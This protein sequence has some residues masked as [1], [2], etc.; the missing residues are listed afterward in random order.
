[1]NESSSPG[2]AAAVGAASGGAPRQAGG[3]YGA[4]AYV[5]D[6]LMSDMP[7]GEWLGWLEAYWSKI[8]RP[9]TVV[10]LGCGTGT[11]AI[12]LAQAGIHVTGIDLSE[13]MLAVARHKEAAVRSELRVPGA[14]RWLRADM[15]EWSLPEPVDAAVSLCDCI[16]YLPTEDDVLR[17]FRRAY[18]GLRPGGSFLFDA[19][20]R[21]RLDMYAENEPFCL[22]DDEVSYI[23]YCDLD[24]DAD[25]VTHRLTFFLPDGDGRYAR[26]KETHRQ[27]AYSER[28]LRELL[29]EAGFADVE[30][31][32]DFTFDPVDDDATLRMFFAARRGA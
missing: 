23:W 10:D 6:K 12:P 29:A 15:R 32:A 28:K 17:A 16:N 22:D 9:A 21:N 4:F 5:Y 8:G 2:A 11:I 18:E 24:E 7:Y 26:V 31:Y 25:T 13:D 14:L 27:R 20:H 1:M 30:T 19:H 3:P